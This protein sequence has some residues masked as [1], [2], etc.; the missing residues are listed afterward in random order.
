M[1]H[2]CKNNKK[3]L[4]LGKHEIFNALN[5]VKITVMVALL[6]AN[7]EQQSSFLYWQDI[8]LK[9]LK[10]GLKYVVCIGRYSEKLHDE[11]DQWLDEYS[12][13]NDNSIGIITT[14]H[15]DETIEEIVDFFLYGIVFDDINNKCSLVVVDHDSS[16]DLQLQKKLRYS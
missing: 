15:P 5:K 4:I 12:I 1:I 9:L 8:I 10:R 14:F 16:F 13:Q 6:I 11:I 2:I 7:E 3:L